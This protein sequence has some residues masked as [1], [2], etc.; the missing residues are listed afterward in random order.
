MPAMPR[1]L[2]A[3]F[4]VMTFAACAAPSARDPD[5]GDAVATVR[6]LIAADQ[7][8]DLDAALRCYS[9]DVVWLP[10]NAAEVRG[11]DVIAARY[12]TMFAAYDPRL[13]VDVVEH[14][15]TGDL[16][17]V[18]GVTHG[19]LRP[20]GAS[21]AVAVHDAFVALLRRADDGWRITHLIWHPTP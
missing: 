7:R 18:R 21:D 4:A 16:A 5:A 11:R 10:P 2:S 12:R 14:R 19:E 1:I 8:R 6:A 13:D 9:D 15:A 3:L 20:R 17:F